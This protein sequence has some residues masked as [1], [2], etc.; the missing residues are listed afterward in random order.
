MNRRQFLSTTTVAPLLAQTKPAQN[1]VLIVVDDLGYKDLNCYSTPS[2]PV[3]YPTPNINALARESTRFNRFY[4]ACPVCSPTRASILTGKYPVRSEITDWIPGAGAPPDA[5]LETPANRLELPLAERTI[6]EYLKP[7][8]YATAS[9]GKWHL[10]GAG[11]SPTDQGFDLNV[12]GDDKGQP[13]SYLAPFTM[14]GLGN[15]PDKAELTHYLT[16]QANRWVAEQAAAQKPFFLYLAHFGVHTPL[17]ADPEKIR[18]YRDA[19]VLSPTYAAMIEAIDDSLGALRA[20]LERSGVSGNTMIVFTSDNGPLL[21]VRGKGSTSVDPLR[22]QKGYLYEGGI[23]VPCIIH[24]PR[25]KQGAVN[26]AP[27]CS[28]DLLPTIL[29][30]LGQPTPA[31]IDGAAIFGRKEQPLYYWHFPH[32]HSAGGRP[33]GAIIDGDYKLIEHFETGKIELYNLADDISEANDLSG[34]DAARA[35]NLYL[36]LK[37]WREE[38]GAKMPRPKTAAASSPSLAAR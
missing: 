37:R 3:P 29:N 16:R 21:A 23:R 31:G 36:R 9:F 22:A 18:Q 27:A 14:P 34:K 13:N 26:E 15:A 8:G 28:I 32:Y 24:D 25:R 1:V 2:H 38:T 6:A 11:F 19:S 33:G 20:Q 10:G 7:L 35:A 12:G 30:W 17:G 4:A 5:K